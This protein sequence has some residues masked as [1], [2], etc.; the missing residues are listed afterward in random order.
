MHESF[1]TGRTTCFQMERKSDSFCRS[2]ESI[3]NKTSD[4][5]QERRYKMGY[6]YQINYDTDDE[7][8]GLNE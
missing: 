7:S 8:G 5:R 2:N 4:W 6:F 3:E 1:G